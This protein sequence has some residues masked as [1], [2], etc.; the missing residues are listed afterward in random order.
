METRKDFLKKVIYTGGTALIAGFLV[1][2]CNDDTKPV[3][4]GET[5]S[6]EPPPAATANP[7][8]TVLTE[9][10][11]EKRKQLGYVSKT[12]MPESHCGNCALYLKPTD[13]IKFGRCQLFKGKV[14]ENGYCTYWAAIQPQ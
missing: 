12:P 10:D 2:S 11:L 4:A 6:S 5:N 7:A 9:A 13:E 8:D 3:K 1:S 14:E